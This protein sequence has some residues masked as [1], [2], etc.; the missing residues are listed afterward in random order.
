M[1]NKQNIKEDILELV[2]VKLEK[3]QV[4][5]TGLIES[6]E[7]TNDIINELIEE[8][9]LIEKDG[10]ITLSDEG[11]IKAIQL[12]R[13]HRLAERLFIDALEIEDKDLETNACKFEHVLSAEIITAIC[14]L[15]G[16]PKECPH[17]NPIPPGECCKKGLEKAE[18]IVYP[19]TRLKSGET[20]RVKYISTKNHKRLDH[21]IT[22]GVSPG[23][24]IRVHQTFPTFVVR[25][26][27]TDIALDEEVCNDIYI[28]RV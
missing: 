15:L 21:L 17:G 23:N 16:H 24:K 5:R 28:R 20:G 10:F 6:N 4:A 22:L 27:E 9:N 19:L 2:W 1:V 11:K 18:G 3:G 8:N 12:L 26:G 25:V 13:A 14:T 7:I